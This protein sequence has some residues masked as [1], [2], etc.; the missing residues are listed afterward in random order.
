MQEHDCERCSIGI[1]YP[2]EQYEAEVHAYRKRGK[3]RVK[4][5]KYHVVCPND[6]EEDLRILREMEDREREETPVAA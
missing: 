5:Y 4:V 2:G 3:D 1:I 6:P